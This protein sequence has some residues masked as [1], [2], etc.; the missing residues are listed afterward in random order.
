MGTIT[1]FMIPPIV[2]F[3]NLSFRPS[4]KFTHFYKD[5]VF[6]EIV[7]WAIGEEQMNWNYYLY[8]HENKMPK[9]IFENIWLKDKLSGLEGHRKW[10]THEYYKSEKLNNINMHGGI[11]FYEKSG[12]TKGHRS[13]KI[14]CDYGHLY[15]R[16]HGD[17]SIEEIIADAINSAEDAIKELNMSNGRTATT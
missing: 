10:I 12:F 5:I 15:D 7:N 3:N 17:Y 1:Y 4:V 14:G 2:K 9:D 13:V 16:E 11:T 6:I 8:L